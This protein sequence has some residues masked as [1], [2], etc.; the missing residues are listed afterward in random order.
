MGPAMNR[1]IMLTRLLPAVACLALVWGCEAKKLSQI[2]VVVDTDLHVPQDLDRFAIKIENLGTTHSNLDYNLD[3]D[4]SGGVKLPATLAILAGSDLAQ[5]VTV[6][7]TG[8]LDVTELLVRRARLPF[9]EGRVL[10]LRMNLLRK[11][12]YRATPCPPGTTCTENGC[13]SIDIDPVSLPDYDNNTANKGLDAALPDLGQDAGPDAPKVDASKDLFPD[14][15]LPDAPLP[16][17]PLPDAPLPDVAQPDAPLPDAPLPD[18][19]VPDAPGPDSAKK[20]L[21]PSDL[22]P[23]DTWPT[24]I[25]PPVTKSCAAGWCGIPAGCFAMGSPPH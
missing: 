8:Y 12:A 25:H 17:I 15:P 3:P 21:A 13:K 1:F 22:P 11:C 14:A 18:S 4:K 16:D 20:D 10:M 2:V 24:C 9:A 6:T 5:R 7:V 23:P 19:A